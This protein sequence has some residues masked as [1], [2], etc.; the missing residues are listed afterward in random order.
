MPAVGPAGA[1]V[2]LTSVMV[3]PWKL[4][5]PLVYVAAAVMLPSGRLDGLIVAVQVPPAMVA[6]KT[7]PPTLSDTALTVGSATPETTSAVLA[8]AALIVLVV[9]PVTALRPSGALQPATGPGTPGLSAAIVIAAGPP[10]APPA[11]GMVATSAVALSRPRAMSPGVSPAK[12]AVNALVPAASKVSAPSMFWPPLPPVEKRGVLETSRASAAIGLPAASAALPW[13]TRSLPTWVGRSTV[14]LGAV[15]VVPA[16][17]PMVMTS[18]GRIS[19]VKAVQQSSGSGA[20]MPSTLRLASPVPSTL[21]TALAMT[22]P[23][24]LTVIG[25]A[26]TGK[27]DSVTDAVL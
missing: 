22:V 11:G 15:M 3:T 21:A 10:A 13:K 7:E 25:V 14:K 9:A 17:P 18:P 23:S 16:A 24:R 4:P 5:A 2:S 1:T 20:T 12:R 26:P 27:V 8:I 6:G 19:G